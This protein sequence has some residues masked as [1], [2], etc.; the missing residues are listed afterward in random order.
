MTFREEIT[1]ALAEPPDAWLLSI[2]A[3]IENPE[4][5][6]IAAPAPVVTAAKAAKSC[7]CPKCGGS[8]KLYQFRHVSGG[9]CFRCN[10][11]RYITA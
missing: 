5:E 3:L 11:A 6:P 2:F 9:V 10:G 4:P 7:V 8:G 1:A